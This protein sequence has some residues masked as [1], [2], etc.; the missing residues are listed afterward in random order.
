MLQEDGE[1]SFLLEKE[2]LI[3]DMDKQQN[4]KLEKTKD[5]YKVLAKKGGI[6]KL[7]LDKKYQTRF[8]SF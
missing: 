4:V 5:G 8:Y 7:K 1:E 2:N 3:Y 6:L